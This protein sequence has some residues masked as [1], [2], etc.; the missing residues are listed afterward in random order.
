MWR[1][2]TFA[3][4]PPRSNVFFIIFALYFYWLIGS[5]LEAQWGAFR[6]NVFYFFGLL[7]SLV[8]G[9]VF[10]YATNTFVNLS[11]FLAFAILFPDFEIMILFILPVKVKYIAIIDL[12]ALILML[13]LL[14]LSS[15]LM[16]IV[17]LANVILFFWR[18]F[19][20]GIKEKYTRFKYRRS[21]DSYWKK[22]K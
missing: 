17:S 8:I 22:K 5:G 20:D 18:D 11:L 9:L 21:V 1:V 3:F 7:C 15:K 2:L 14:P 10:G 13:I 12:V 4:L 6:F 16:I 19:I